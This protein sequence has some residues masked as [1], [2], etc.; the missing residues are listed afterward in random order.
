MS[1]K[2]KHDRQLKYD[3]TFCSSLGAYDAN[4]YIYIY[5]YIIV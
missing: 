5:I 1:F 2:G 4:I 3:F